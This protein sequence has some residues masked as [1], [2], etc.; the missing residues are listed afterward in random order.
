MLFK[1]KKGISRF[2]PKGNKGDDRY[3]SPFLFLNWVIIG[4][5]IVLGISIFYNLFIDIRVQESRVL[6]SNILN[7]FSEEGYFNNNVLDKDFDFYNKCRLNKEILDESG[8]YYLR[9][10]I[11]GVNQKKEF[12]IG[13]KDLELQCKLGEKIKDNEK[14]PRC[15]EDLI[16][17]ND[18]QGNKFSI[19]IFSVSNQKGE[20]V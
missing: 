11:E 17:L 8:L 20:K 4:V 15:S 1:N 14:Y 16:N 6:N 3:I 10:K 12:E 18:R 9:I 5:A 2:L 7:C 13:K 19:L